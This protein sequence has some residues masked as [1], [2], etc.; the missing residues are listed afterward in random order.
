VEALMPRGAQDLWQQLRWQLQRYFSLLLRRFGWG[1]LSVAA[2]ILV[3][4]MCSTLA[5]QSWL[6]AAH[7]LAQ[8]QL[9]QAA[10][11]SEPLV[12][13]VDDIQLVANYYGA[14]P[15]AAELPAILESLLRQAQASGIALGAGEYR[16]QAG[17][18]QRSIGYRIRFPMAGE[19]A[20]IQSFV[21]GA[22]NRHPSLAL[23]AL[24]MRRETPGAQRVE[25]S[26]QFVLWISQSGS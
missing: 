18:L 3:L 6:S 23:D 1:G 24:S 5:L 14:L 4:V 11:V 21:L 8:L 12:E 19:A 2:G 16:M 10:P 17:A 26:V 7:Q 13:P 20:A 25:A 22:L 9:R 15:P